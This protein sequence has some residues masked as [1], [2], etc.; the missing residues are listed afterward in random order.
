[1]DQCKKCP[2]KSHLDCKKCD[3]SKNDICD[4]CERCEHKCV[5][6]ECYC[7]CHSENDIDLPDD[8]ASDI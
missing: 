8:D 4:N 5:C 3:E 1:M 2:C 6:D 7:E